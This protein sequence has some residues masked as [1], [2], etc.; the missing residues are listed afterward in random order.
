MSY[1]ALGSGITTPLATAAIRPELAAGV[2]DV[3]RSGGAVALPQLSPGAVQAVAAAQAMSLEP[4]YCDAVMRTPFMP[5]P[6]EVPAGSVGVVAFPVV[7]FAGSASKIEQYLDLFI[8]PTVTAGAP[9][10]PTGALIP[11]PVLTT[12]MLPGPALARWSTQYASGSPA[13]PAD[14]RM[15]LRYFACGWV[16]E[17][18]TR[19]TSRGLLWFAVAF[20]RAVDG[21]RMGQL[22]AALPRAASDLGAGQTVGGHEL[23]DPITRQALQGFAPSALSDI[24]VTTLGLTQLASSRDNA[25]VLAAVYASALSTAHLAGG[26]NT[27]FNPAEG[28]RE[29]VTISRQIGESAR[30]SREAHEIVQGLPEIETAVDTAIAQALGGP[31]VEGQG[32]I[33]RAEAA[34][35]TALAKLEEGVR[36]APSTIELAARADSELKPAIERMIREGA[37]R[38]A[39][40]S[41]ALSFSLMKSYAVCSAYRSAAGL[42]ERIKM[43]MDAD[44]ASSVE[45]ARAIL[46]DRDRVTTAFTR[47]GRLLEKLTVAK[48][49]LPLEW[50]QRTRYGLPVWGWGAAGAAVLVGGALTVRLLRKRKRVSPNRRRRGR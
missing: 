29:A 22:L 34:V 11:S 12:A 7:R 6:P 5:L 48:E 44:I 25:A 40:S 17:T 2:R 3:A 50:F 43:Q 16:P 15:A 49:Q 30:K 19:A 26:L 14:R 13:A 45:P 23:V 31:P 41:N 8:A 28:Q 42:I 33:D 39:A 20:D 35:R 21:V 37:D 1:R 27:I 46:A 10:A 4:W 32:V 38:V 36:S 24:E 47:L 18:G 9:P